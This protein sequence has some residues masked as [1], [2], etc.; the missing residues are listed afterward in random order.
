M[1]PAPPVAPSDAEELLER[2]RG[3][4][5]RLRVGALLGLVLRIGEAVGGAAI[6]FQLERDLGGTAVNK[7]PDP[8]FS[9]A[10]DHLPE[11]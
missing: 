8:F 7:R 1:S 6:D 10:N 9:R 4:G 2:S 3:R 11:L 5:D